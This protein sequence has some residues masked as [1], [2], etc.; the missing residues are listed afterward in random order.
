M[1]N[2]FPFRIH[3][4]K[5]GKLRFLSHHDL[6]RTFE[7]A[8]RRTELP[9]RFTEGFNPHPH[10]SFPTALGIGIESL[11]EIAEVE[12]T[13]WIAPK[14]IEIRINMQMPEGI[15]IKS[16]EP[17][18]RKNRSVIEFVEYDAKFL[19]P[20]QDFLKGI[21]TRID[22]FLKTPEVILER[23][24]DKGT[25]LIDVRKYALAITLNGD[26]ISL[27]IKITDSGTAKPEEVLK[28]LGIE[29]PSPDIRITKARTEIGRR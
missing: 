28:A 11:D 17:F 1:S 29:V 7:R 5:E 12:L 20:M 6:M 4:T 26:T 25:K 13:S 27:K 24:S 3:F 14:Q 15:K 10:I 8:L 2:I 23:Q 9:L 19:K 16:V 21:N 18:D 22:N